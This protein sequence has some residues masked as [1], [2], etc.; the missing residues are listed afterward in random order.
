MPKESVLSVADK[1]AIVIEK[2]IFHIIL[3]DDVQPVFL[4]EL[5][6]TKEQT[7]F[8]K[9]RLADSAQGRQY[10]F[11]SNNAAV[12]KL[13]QSV[14]KSP[15]TNFIKVSKDLTDRFKT[16]HTGSTN[17]GVFVIALA[18]IKKRKLLFMVKIDHKKVYEYKLKGNKALLKEVQN[19][20][21][22]D[23]SAIQ[24]VALIDISPNVVWD[25]LVY[26][27]SKPSS[28]TEYFRNFLSVNPRETES[29]LTSNAVSFVLKWASNNRDLL[30][31]EQEPSQYKNRAIEHLW[32]IDTFDTDTF[33]KSV[34]RDEDSTRRGNLES[35]LR[36]FLIEKGLAGQTFDV[37]RNALTKKTK[38]NVRQTAEGVKIEWTGE[39]K[40]HNI[41]IPNEPN[42][43]GIY[44]IIIETSDI[45]EIQ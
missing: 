9:D 42:N 12:R 26:D 34:I 19:T 28:I 44:R 15:E 17:D 39:P 22:E 18:S 36:D 10:I 14:I 23:K 16:T 30:D 31:P 40:D 25:V 45:Q 35:S 24:K 37:N 43:N 3:K 6:I 4:D 41:T 20:F 38:K 1:E 13:T 33:I 11:T 32:N 2:L 27:R 7:K 5:V 21:V 29:Q 8:F